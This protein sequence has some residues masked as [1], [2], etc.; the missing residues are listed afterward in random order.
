MKNLIGEKNAIFFSFIF[1]N[2]RFGKFCLDLL[3]RLVS[4]FSES[5]R[6]VLDHFG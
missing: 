1:A 4:I 5:L 3:S 6:F 2:G